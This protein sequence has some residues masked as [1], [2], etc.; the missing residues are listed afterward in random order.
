MIDIS[1]TIFTIFRRINTFFIK[2]EIFN[3]LRKLLLRHIT[4]RSYD[5]YDMSRI[6]SH[7]CYVS[8]ILI[9]NEDY[10]WF[11]IVDRYVISVT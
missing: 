1:W 9:R 5:S 11:A 2:S 3:N 8:D 6:M 10:G 7:I 4:H